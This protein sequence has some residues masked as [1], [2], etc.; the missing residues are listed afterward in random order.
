MADGS[1]RRGAR[2]QRS[3]GHVRA[4]C[5]DLRVLGPLWCDIGVVAAP[6]R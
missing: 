5:K 1:G 4:G 2:C 6:L 3:L